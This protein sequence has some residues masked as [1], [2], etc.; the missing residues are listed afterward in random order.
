MAEH[1]DCPHCGAEY[2]YSA[3]GLREQDIAD[4]E[5]IDAINQR[6]AQRRISQI[7]QGKDLIEECRRQML[8]NQG[9]A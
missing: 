5:L 1:K 8:A 2:C 3:D 7:K 9:A 4:R 6:D